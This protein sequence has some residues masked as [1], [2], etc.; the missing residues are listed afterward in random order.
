LGEGS[1]GGLDE[2]E[3][4]DGVHD[5]HEE[6]VIF[7]GA[8]TQDS[9]CAGT[10]DSGL[11]VGRLQQATV[12]GYRDRHAYIRRDESGGEE[13]WERQPAHQK[14]YRKPNCRTRPPVDPMMRPAF[15]FGALAGP[16]SVSGSFQL[17]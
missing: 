2:G 9:R 11:E 7:G 4:A 1:A 14:L 12:C 13:K 5:D 6:Q 17:A 15:A 3:V 8:Y 10:L 16:M